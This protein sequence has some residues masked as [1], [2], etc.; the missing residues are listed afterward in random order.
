MY[1]SPPDPND[2]D[3]FE[4]Y[5]EASLKWSLFPPQASH[6]LD[7]ILHN[8]HPTEICPGFCVEGNSTL[9]RIRKR[10][11]NILIYKSECY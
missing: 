6:F 10:R 1:P 5:E 4:K 2:Y 9:K 11:F 8:S 7:K 3:S